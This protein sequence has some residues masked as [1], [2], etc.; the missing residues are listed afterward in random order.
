VRHAWTRE[1]I[2]AGLQAFAREHGRPPSTLDLRDTRGTPNP[3]GS[4]VQ[5][6][7]GSHRAALAQLGS[8]AGWTPVT[9]ADI[10]EALR[11]YERE[12]GTLPTCAAWRSQRRRPAASV[13]IR[14]HGTW[15]AA[16]AA[17]QT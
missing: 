14:R 7:F 13:I 6:T 11:T 5:R 16:L 12:H 4:A 9:N 1:H 8:T 15:N 3:P 10:V 2:L 17:A